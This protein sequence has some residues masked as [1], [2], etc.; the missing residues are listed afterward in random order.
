MLFVFL[1]LGC[2]LVFA[3]LSLLEHLRISALRSRLIATTGEVVTV[4]FDKDGYH[5]VVVFSLP[6]GRQVEFWSRTSN[7]R[8]NEG[9]RVNV[10]YPLNQPNEAKVD[11]PEALGSRCPTLLTLAI[12]SAI[13]GS[14]ILYVQ[15]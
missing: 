13:I 3:V 7:A 11:H 8:F 4:S 2:A 9:Q 1:F 12:L 5:P 10:L 14:S 6:D 15:S